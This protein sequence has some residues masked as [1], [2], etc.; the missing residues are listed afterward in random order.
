LR[1]ILYGFEVGAMKRSWNGLI[2]AG[3][4]LVI[5]G[6]V[7]YPLYFV[8][9]PALRDF[10]WANLPLMAVGL[11]LIGVGVVR[12]FRQ[13]ERYRGK[14]FGSIVGVLMAALALVF[15]Y[16]L[17]VGARH[18]LPSAKGAPQVGQIAPDF[19]LADS[20]NKPVQLSALLNSSFA[21]NGDATGAGSAGQTAGVV[22]IFYR[23]YW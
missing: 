7:S 12:A 11:A 15:C 10:P 19:T 22:L 13:P 2:W 4:L 23:G 3:A 8:R 21:G 6:V 14:V 5:A 18:I 9:F 1:E 17:F 16:G 20:Q